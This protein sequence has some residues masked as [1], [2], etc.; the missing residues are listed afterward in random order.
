MKILHR[1]NN[2]FALLTEGALT[3]LAEGWRELKI[4]AGVSPE[5]AA[6]HPIIAK[7]KGALKP[8]VSMDENTGIATIPISGVLARK[9]DLYEMYNGVEDSAAILGVIQDAA[10]NPKVKGVLLD[11]DSPGGFITGGPE[12][13]E[14]VRDMSRIKPVVAWTGGGMESL[15]Y[16]IGSQASEVIASKSAMVG[17]IG[18]FRTFVD[19]SR[20]LDNAGIKV[21]VI[22]NKEA[23]H[24]A[25]GVPGTSL[26]EEQRQFMQ[27]SAQATFDDFKSA[28]QTARPQVKDGSMTGRSFSGASAKAA[29]LIDAVGDIGY[30]MARLKG[31]IARK[32]TS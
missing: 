14:A 23:K 10:I 21:D 27:D 7:L 8:V 4:E 29:G 19:R 28:V 11:I 3:A 26:S 9:P 1:L 24:K 2:D 31:A 30:A 13:A 25:I 17:S 6:D 16:Y 5:Q 12:V 20:M 18:V 15:A 32:A 22:K